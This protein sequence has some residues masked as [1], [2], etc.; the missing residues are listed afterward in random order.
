MGLPVTAANSGSEAGKMISRKVLEF[1]AV[2]GQKTMKRTISPKRD[3][4]AIAEI[5][6]HGCDLPLLP[7]KTIQ[8]RHHRH[9]E[10]SLREIT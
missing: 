9:A 3:I 8:R 6:D 7:E 10:I 2:V 1:Y 5:G 4:P